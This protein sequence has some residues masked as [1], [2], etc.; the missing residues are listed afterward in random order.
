MGQI[1]YL[2][3]KYLP[4]E[5]AKVSVFDHGYLYGDGVFEGIRAYNNSVFRLQDHVNRLYESAQAIC[6][7]I[8]MG[9][10]EMKQ[11]I[12]ET[13]RQN[14]IRDGYIRVVVSRGVGDLGLDPQKCPVPMVVV[15]AATISLYPEELYRNGMAVITVPTRRNGPE[16]VNPRIKS[17]NY[18]NNIMAKMEANLAG[19]GEAILLN[20]EGYVAECS[21]DNI[22]IVKDGILKTPAPHVGILE[23]ITRNEVIKLAK[24]Q[25]ILVEETVFTRFELFTADEVFLTGSGAELIAVVKVDG[26]TIADGKPGPVFAALLQGFREVVKKPEA[27]IFA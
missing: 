8:P 20:Q 21:G 26:R 7:E 27:V 14:D 3:G 2:G 4:K 11:V 19:V 5:E 15:I 17:L 23:G 9:K 18:L 24:R 13:C 12:L 25:G 1:I 22:F 10:E 16:G 6:L